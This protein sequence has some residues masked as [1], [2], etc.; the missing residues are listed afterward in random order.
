MVT[1]HCS[2][3]EKLSLGVIVKVSPPKNDRTVALLWLPVEAQLM[4][5]Q[6][7]ST[8]TGSVK[9]TV[10]VASRGA[11]LAPLRGSVAKTA[12]PISTI[13]AVRRGNGAPVTKSARLL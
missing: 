4:S 2:P 1:V 13:G 5:Y 8:V 12:G 3:A 11:E 10:M 9:L 7:L 6:A